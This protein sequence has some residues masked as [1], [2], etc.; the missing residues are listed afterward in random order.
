MHRPRA[1]DGCRGPDDLRSEE[2]V[3]ALTEEMEMAAPKGPEGTV[4]LFHPNIVHASA[5]N[6]SPHRR[7][8]IEPEGAGDSTDRSRHRGRRA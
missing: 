4:L 6:V 3:R 7:G 5:Q 1:R 8:T 2:Q